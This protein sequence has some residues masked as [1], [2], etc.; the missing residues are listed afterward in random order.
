MISGFE[1]VNIP[2]CSLPQLQVAAVSSDTSPQKSKKDTNTFEKISASLIGLGIIGYAGYKIAKKGSLNVKNAA[3]SVSIFK[4][5]FEKSAKIPSMVWGFKDGRLDVINN[6]CLKDIF[7]QLDNLTTKGQKAFV[8]EYCEMTGFPDIKKVSQNIEDEIIAKIN[9]M[10]KKGKNK[11]LFAGYDANCS[12]GRRMALPG[13][14]CDGLFVVMENRCNENVNCMV[15]GDSINQRLVE[16][17]GKHY[18]EVWSFEDMKEAINQVEDIFSRHLKMFPQK[19]E[20]YKSLLT[21]DGKD[22]IRAAQFNVDVADLIENK[23]QKDMACRAAFFVEYLRAGKI[24]LN[25]MDS[26]KIRF[27]KNSALYRFSNVTRQE[28]FQKEVKPKLQNRIRLAHDFSDMS[29]RE[30]FEMCRNI[31]KSSCGVM[32][33]E[34]KDFF[35]NFDMGNINALYKKITSFQD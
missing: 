9:Q 23:F 34:T 19:L 13:S 8:R 4:E 2:Y 28:A 26:D 1:K 16:T 6:P 14:D 30:Q 24:L 35:K 15:L 5:Y 7:S 25:N 33:E 22:F 3:D 18:P 11:V 32:L 17:T 21:Y 27:I 29:G 31:M 20:Q 10:S 12:V